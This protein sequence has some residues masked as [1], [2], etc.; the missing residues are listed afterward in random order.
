MD[1]QELIKWIAS[2]LAG[3]ICIVMG[4]VAIF[5]GLRADGAIDLAALAKG[6]VKTG[7]MGLLLL[8]FGSVLITALVIHEKETSRVTIRLP[9]GTTETM[10]FARDFHFPPEEDVDKMLGRFKA[11]TPSADK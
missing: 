4:I 5:R 10:V 7:S 8:F 2:P 3:L 11:A 9:N 6:K 1:N